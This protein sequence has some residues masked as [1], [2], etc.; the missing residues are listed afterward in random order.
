[1]VFQL[2]K[3]AIVG[4]IAAFVD[5]GVLV[6]LK[7]LFSVD[8]L[9][10]SAVSFS[11]SV[12]VNYILSMAFVFKSKK[13]SKVK[14]FIIFVLLSIGGLG[15]NQLIL[16]IGVTFT[17]VYYLVIKFLAMVIVPIYNF[18]TRKIFLEEKEK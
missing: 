2:L 1:M 6:F 9:I 17:S 11:V 8:V 12:T 18:I 15:L 7:E 14:E 3:F 13:Q 16:W 5:V 4:V 10:A